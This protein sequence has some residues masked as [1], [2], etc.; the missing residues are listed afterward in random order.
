[1]FVA[2][3]IIARNV[4]NLYEEPSASSPLDT[5]AVL[6]EIVQLEEER[7][8]FCRVV[9][10]SDCYSGWID[11][12][13]L[14]PIKDMAPLEIAVVTRLFADLLKNPSPNAELE[15][16]LVLGTKV[17]LAETGTKSQYLKVVLPSEHYAYIEKNATQSISQTGH[18]NQTS[19]QLPDKI[20]ASAA[21]FA[22]PLIG[23]PYLWG[24]TTPFG[25]DCSGLVQLCFKMSG[26]QMQRNASMQ[27]KDSRFNKIEIGKSLAQGQ[28]QPGDL[29]AF[30]YPD[31]TN[32]IG[33][34]LGDG[35][36][37]HSSGSQNNGG[38]YIDD[39]SHPMF[40]E[41]FAGASRLASTASIEAA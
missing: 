28:F 32:H 24:G 19:P 29:L 20:S 37:I 25:I 8:G 9:T 15:A 22:K 16:K 34:A 2:T 23:T 10:G 5:Q 3:H 11:H 27:A 13:W 33:F 40:N 6:N 1:M 18:Q 17:Y 7:N 31:K 30:V 35:R 21:N 36:F 4:A 41:I 38:V 14:T 39:C 12:R 26:V